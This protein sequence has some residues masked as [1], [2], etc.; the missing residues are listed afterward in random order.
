MLNN[1]EKKFGYELLAEITPEND[2]EQKI[3][4]ILEN[5]VLK[6]TFV[7]EFYSWLSCILALHAVNKGNFG[8]GCVLVD[9]N[10]DVEFM[11]HNM[12]FTPYFRSDRHA[13]MVVMNKFEDKYKGSKSLN[14]YTLYSSLESCPMCLTRLITS[15]IGRVFYLAPDITGGMVHKIDDLPSIWTELT[16]SKVFDQA[17]CSQ[18][19]QELAFEI[20]CLNADELNERIV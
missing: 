4:G 3:I 1:D 2:D 17:T 6:P 14:N 15:G 20:F 11:G 13:E 7:D 12:V 19:L 5:Y 10:G 16:Q 8:V 18:Q 9:Q